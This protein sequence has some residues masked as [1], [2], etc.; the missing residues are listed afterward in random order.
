MYIVVGGLVLNWAMISMTHLYFKKAMRGRPTAFPALFS[1]LV[2]Y[3]CLAFLAM[4]LVIMWQQGFKQSVILLPIWVG[5]MYGVYWLFYQHK[6]V[7][8]S[9]P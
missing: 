4:M 9:A 8:S 1:P 6:K 2:N 5:L 7:P 3:V